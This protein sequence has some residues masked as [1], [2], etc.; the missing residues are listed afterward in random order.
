MA[1]DKD[2]TLNPAAQQRKL[3]KNRALK[4]GKATVQAQRNERLAQ[5][6]PERLQREVDEL[7]QLEE[8]GGLK[9]RDKQRLEQLEQQVKGIRKARDALGDKAPQFGRGGGGGERGRGSERGRGRGGREGGVLGKRRRDHDDAEQSS[10]TDEEARDIPMPKDVENEPPI[11]RRRGPPRN[12]NETPMGKSRMPHAL[13]DKPVAAPQAQTVYESKPVIRDLKKEAARFVPSTVAQK[14]KKI[15]GDGGRL[16][17]PEEADKLEQEGYNAA[18]GV[19]NEMEKEAEYKMMNVEANPRP[20]DRGNGNLSLEEE[21]AAFRKELAKVEKE[22]AQDG[23]E[24]DEVAEEYDEFG[25]KISRDV[26]GVAQEMEKEAG[27]KMMN[28]EALGGG[29]KG[30]EQAIRGVELEEVEDEDEGR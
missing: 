9:L 18:R 17:E 10:E 21:E 7:K 22:D 23:S 4:K 27:F 28:V 30:F 5:R 24:L 19:A 3:D 29:N 26:E 15:K 13:P 6:N 12:A 25:Q 11:P 8:A 16:L 2:K 1:K 20:G 14:I